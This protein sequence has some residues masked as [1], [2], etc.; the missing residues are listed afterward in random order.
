M[1]PGKYNSALT[2][3]S[4]TVAWGRRPLEARHS[5]ETL[6]LP[7]L[8]HIRFAEQ[9]RSRSDR[10]ALLDE[11]ETIS[12]GHLRA[13]AGRVAESLLRRGI[14]RGS[15]VGLQ[16]ERSIRA[17]AAMLGI[18]ESGAAVVPLPPSYP[19]ERR[20]EICSFCELDAVL[21]TGGGSDDSATGG[22]LMEVEELLADTGPNRT[23]TGSELLGGGP[24]VHP[25]DPAFILS[26]SGSTGHPKMIV[27]SH[28][29]F[30]H[31][32]R[33]TWT[34][35]PFEE[36]DVGCQKA[37]MTTTHSIYELFEPLLAG[38][39]TVIVSDDGA[40][41][42][43]RF[44]DTVRTRGVTRLLIVPSA[45][46]ASLDMPGFEPPGLRVVVL[47]GEY[48][49]PELAARAARSFPQGTRLYSI[50]G[51][52]EA[53]S[54]LVVD[55]RES[56]QPGQELP[57]GVPISP[58]V[59]ALVL[60][61][62]LRRVKA[63]D[64]GRL[65]IAG[66][67]L[68][69]GYLND[70]ELTASVLVDAPGHEETLY[71]TRDDV[72]R[73]NDGSLHFVG[74][75]DD[76]VKVRGFRV[77]LPEVERAIRQHSEV[78]Q[79][80]VVV[81]GQETENARLVGFFVPSNVN[82]GDV[83]ETVREILPA[84]MVPAALIGLDRFPL[85]AS[86]KVDRIR[87]LD[88]AEEERDGQELSRD[89]SETEREVVQAWAAVLG[90]GS[91]DLHDSFFEVGGTSLT[92]F[93]AV[94]RL[95]EV[96]GLD[97]NRLAE[98][99]L[100]QY[101][102]VPELAAYIDGILGGHGIATDSGETPVL[103]RLRN[104]EG[105]TPGRAPLFMVPSAG[106]TLGAYERLT[107]TLSSGREILGIRDPYLWNRRDPTEDFQRWIDHYLEAM[108]QRQPRG[109]Y[110]ICA[111]SSACS[112]GY[113]IARRLR[114]EGEEVAILTLIDP[115]VLDQ[116]SE[117]RYGYWV[118]RATW[119]RP[120]LREVVRLAGRVRRPF[121]RLHWLFRKSDFSNRY[122]LSA[123][124]YERVA[125]D[126][127]TSRGHLLRLA[128]LFE[129]N[130]GL[131]FAMVEEDF[132]GVP[133]DG[134]LAVLQSHVARITP[135]VKP[136]SIERIA[137]QYGIQARAQ[138]AYRLQPYDGR[139]LLVEPSSGYAGIVAEQLRPY[140]SDLHRRVVE[141]GPPGERIRAISG[142]FGSLATHYRSM[143]DDLFVQGLAREM[144]EMLK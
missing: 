31:R 69:S 34:H 111:Y 23:H 83:F 133:Q 15:R 117:R 9:A 37:H 79:A 112:F 106:G 81:S 51:S 26:S 137:I 105:G 73:M 7:A 68:F 130:T 58:D 64:V 131:P 136:E 8:L 52:T 89:L 141:I 33:W 91:F 95:R 75:V 129:L 80:A 65:H 132:S 57:L 42:L 139:V 116:A 47:M 119:M 96:F 18:L 128:A 104:A 87:L 12:Y 40:R 125:D 70:P 5:T 103:V 56:L 99:T 2:A 30:F 97:R 118:T 134:Y 90:H 110:H 39:P 109:P 62:E 1:V 66:T 107:K 100:Y 46:R 78:L 36:D 13:Q 113:E 108:R 123:E 71:D 4:D 14:G 49:P 101:P 67:P 84:Y 115:L 126:A 41:N 53:S 122:A 86:A 27:R 19:V 76:T 74:R 3:L 63:G 6:R 61:P 121:I 143:R 11:K 59:T 93:A 85:T 127:R 120:A 20:R 45:L 138:H 29:S 22:L 54:T 28:R 135:E 32:L 43:E 50:Y 114:A 72:R 94:H 124:E 35:N 48:V 144:D 98:E 24:R 60:D 10:V 77:E 25:G 44:W 102:T 17:V 16:M 140:V 92:V 38:A 55:L 21:A 88:K 82:P 142:L